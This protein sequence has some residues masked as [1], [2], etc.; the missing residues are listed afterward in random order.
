M[1]R[2]GFLIGQALGTTRKRL[3][4]ARASLASSPRSNVAIADS[5]FRRFSSVARSCSLFVVPF[6]ACGATARALNQPLFPAVNADGA[7]Y[8]DSE[9][10]V[11]I[12]MKFSGARAFSEDLAPV[13][14]GGYW[15]YLKPNGEF[16]IIPQLMT[17]AHSLAALRRCNG[18]TFGV[19]WMPV[20]R[21]PFRAHLSA[22]NHLSASWRS[23][24][25]KAR[26]C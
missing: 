8:I 1:L 12:A 6:V 5:R 7:G 22:P 10:K 16:A 9:G 15:G 24:K 14:L 26:G 13:E 17:P 20:E 2:G 25:P 11:L 21:L 19:T 23:L 3:A 4:C 18:A